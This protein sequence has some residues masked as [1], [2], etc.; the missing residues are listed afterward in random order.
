[1]PKM[2]DPVFINVWPKQHSC[3]GSYTIDDW[4]KLQYVGVQKAG[5]LASEI[6]DLELRQ[7]KCGSTLAITC[8]DDIIEKGTP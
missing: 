3:G 7:C 8:P 4:E 6:P 5:D 2:L 1:M